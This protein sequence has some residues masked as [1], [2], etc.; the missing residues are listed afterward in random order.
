MFENFAGFQTVSQSVM[1]G[2]GRR[3]SSLDQ[4]RPHR[5]EFRFHAGSRDA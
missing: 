5:L 2:Q 4:K 3:E 1:G